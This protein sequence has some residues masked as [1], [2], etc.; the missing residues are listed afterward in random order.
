MEEKTSIQILADHYQKTFEVSYELWKHRN[1][2]YFLL[3]GVVGVAVL[4]TFQAP[5]ANSLLVDWIAKLV[6]VTEPDR[7]AEIQNGFP[8]AILYGVLGL[9]IFYIMLIVYQYSRLLRHNYRY[10]GNLEKELREQLHL[11]EES[12]FFTRENIYVRRSYET[13]AV[14]AWTYVIS[15]GILLIAFFGGRLIEDI[16]SNDLFLSIVDIILS[17]AV[18]FYFI[19]YKKVVITEREKKE[20]GTTETS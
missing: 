8:F 19:L 1:K 10:L 13:G 6:G 7:I 9:A 4:L 3:L 11:G 20:D 14:I 5:Q 17:I 12:E 16:S 15:L 18:M 2:L